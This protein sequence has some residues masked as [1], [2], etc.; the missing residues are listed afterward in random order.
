MRL[1][2]ALGLFMASLVLLL[3]GVAQR[4]VWAPPSEYRMSVE[5]DAAN[6]FVVV[7]NATLSAHPGV[8]IV[9]TSG[10]NNLF[11]ATGRESDVLAW[12]GETS[13]TMI[14]LE[15]EKLVATSVTG[16]GLKA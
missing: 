6:P 9:T 16:S 8:P 7:P 13:H 10:S 15:D 1:L 3:V 12:V 11:I 4:T 2:I 14:S 5:F